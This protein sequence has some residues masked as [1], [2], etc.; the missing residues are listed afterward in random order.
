MQVKRFSEAKP[1]EAPNH[2][3]FTGVARCLAPRPAAPRA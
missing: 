1:Y 3:D 2:R